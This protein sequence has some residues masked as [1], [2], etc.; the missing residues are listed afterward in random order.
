LR[1]YY[2]NKS[3]L[4][5]FSFEMELHNEYNNRITEVINYISNNLT[6]DLSL[7]KLAGVANFSPYHFQ[8]LFKRITGETPKQY[9]M[10]V[11]LETAAH[12][13]IIHPHKSITE[14]SIDL[15]FTSPSIFSRAF[16]NFFGITP[17][18][19]R[20]VPTQ[21]RIELYKKTRNLKA[22]DS[23]KPER[24]LKVLIKRMP[25]IQGIA[26]NASLANLTKIQSTYKRVIQ[27]AGTNDL[28]SSQTNF[29]GIMNPNQDLYR[30][31]VTIN[32]H[33]HIKKN[34]IV[35]QIPS[36]KYACCKL[37]GSTDNT[38]KVMQQ[39]VTE[40][41]PESGY[42]MADIFCF[43]ILS[44]SPLKKPYDKIPRE[45]YFPIEPSQRK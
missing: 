2:R 12:F 29:I 22:T 7:E 26:M 37:N 11:R 8:K 27:L 23:P 43:E 31:M 13:L 14:I 35:A 9:V 34:I 32:F 21:D 44:E 42:N 6:A 4:C 24:K 38:F 41:L 45:I 40:W 16:K 19:L 33:H 10:K 5:G 1:S 25:A 28:I 39:F 15:E 20:A 36:G 3:V 17:D 30:C 18:E